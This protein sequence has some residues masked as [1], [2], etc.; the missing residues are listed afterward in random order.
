MRWCTVA[1][2]KTAMA[3]VLSSRMPWGIQQ[4]A[5][6]PAFKVTP[7]TLACLQPK[8][9]MSHTVSSQALLHTLIFYNV[10]AAQHN[11]NKT[12]W[13]IL[14]EQF[15]LNLMSLLFPDMCRCNLS[16]WDSDEP[17]PRAELLK[18]VAGA[19]GILCLLSDKIDTEVLDAAGKAK[20]WVSCKWKYWPGNIDNSHIKYSQ[21]PTWK[22][23]ALSQLDLTTLL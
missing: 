22:W 3:T 8:S 9:K 13:T 11:L 18:G 4:F 16:V 10:A 17:V 19:H 23:S 6:T 14:C 2:A 7:V 5:F 1:C 15:S 20:L 21:D 12:T